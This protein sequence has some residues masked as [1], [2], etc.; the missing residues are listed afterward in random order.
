VS[1]KKSLL[2]ARVFNVG[3]LGL[4]DIKGKAAKI[5]RLVED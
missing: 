1:V 5:G 2:C 4:T 3:I